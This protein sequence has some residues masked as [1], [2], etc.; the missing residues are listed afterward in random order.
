MMMSQKSKGRIKQSALL[1]RIAVVSA[2]LNSRSEN[3]LVEAIIIPELGL[4]NVEWHVFAANLVEGTHDPTLCFQ[5]S[6]GQ[7][8]VDFPGLG[9]VAALVRAIAT[10]KAI[11]QPGRRTMSCPSPTEPA[12]GLEAH[13][14]GL[15][16]GTLDYKNKLFQRLT[17]DI[18]HPKLREHLAAVL[19]LMKYS[20][21]WLVF[22]DRLD[23]EFPQWGTN[24]MLPF[25]DDY[26][27]PE[28]LKDRVDRGVS[29]DILNGIKDEAAN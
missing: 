24:F 21:N 28:Y 15:R 11:M 5:K 3:V 2:S 23:K 6:A 8:P 27:P 18:G 22:M 20:P 26:E 17:D 4:R 25:P 29:E 16:A 12:I 10:V 7:I 1:R 9:T 13:P 19:M 14:G